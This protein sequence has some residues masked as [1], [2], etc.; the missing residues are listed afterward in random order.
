MYVTVRSATPAPANATVRISVCDWS[1][2]GFRSEQFGGRSRADQNASVRSVGDSS[3]TPA[4]S[5]SS[6][7]SAVDTRPST[8]RRW[9]MTA[10]TVALRRIT[11][12]SS[13]HLS[14]TG[15]CHSASP[16]SR[17]NASSRAVSASY[18]VTQSGDGDTGG[19]AAQAVLQDPGA[20]Q[21]V[22]VQVAVLVEERDGVAEPEGL[23]G[24]GR[25]DG[26]V[27]LD[28][29]ALTGGTRRKC[30]GPEQ[31]LEHVVGE[32]RY[33]QVRVVHVRFLCLLRQ[34]CGQVRVVVG[35]PTRS[36]YPGG[37]RDLVA[38]AGRPG[39]GVRP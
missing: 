16:M 19:A 10:A 20:E 33:L 39:H 21:R 28:G 26:E 32:D 5:G 15:A 1:R 3:G 2:Q 34:P 27:V 13:Y 11:R 4:P 6:R 23:V 14:R 7:P 36:R 9:P 22:E 25:A 37:A 17:R 29:P 31:G 35:R 24:A 18:G 8:A 30:P 38:V 12:S